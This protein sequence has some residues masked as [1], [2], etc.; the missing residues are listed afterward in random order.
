MVE[1]A[2]ADAAD[3]PEVVADVEGIAADKVTAA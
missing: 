2:M 1:V 3:A